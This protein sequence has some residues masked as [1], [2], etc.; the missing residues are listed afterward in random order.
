MALQL[1]SS[2]SPPYLS[3]YWPAIKDI[4]QT[5]LNDASISNL[6]DTIL[7]ISKIN[8]CERAEQID[9]LSRLSRVLKQ[10]R[11][12]A[13]NAEMP[14]IKTICQKALEIEDLFQ[15]GTIQLLQAL[16]PSKLSFKRNEIHCLLAHMFFGTFRCCSQ[17]TYCKEEHT[18]GPFSFHSRMSF[19]NWYSNKSYPTTDIY[20]NA[21]LNLFEDAGKLSD[22]D[23][24][25]DYRVEFERK[26]FFSSE[27]NLNYCD[28]P[29]VKVI[30]HSEGRIGDIEETEVDFANAYV[31]GGPGGTQ[32]ELMLG[33]S[34]ES[35]P[36]SILNADPLRSNECIVITGAKKYAEYKGYGLDAIYLGKNVQKWNWAA[37]KIIAI[38]ALWFQKG[39]GENRFEQM[40]EDLLRREVLKCFVGFSSQTNGI[41]TG[42]WGCG[43]FGGDKE[44]KAILQVI[45]ASAANVKH[46]NFFSF[47][48]KVFA[49]DFGS[50][51][52]AL[53]ENDIKVKDLWKMVIEE[54]KS[55]K[56]PRTY[57]E[58]YD[59]EPFI[60]KKIASNLCYQ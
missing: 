8:Q 15:S 37:R 51:L 18:G 44:I 38:D 43:A 58:R 1:P 21:I 50:M 17:N 40:R 33:I 47:G 20:L 39:T 13:E 41:S 11:G 22:S 45:G 36:I 5:L 59:P 60:F 53:Y 29:L 6:E 32:E 16:K 10:F 35:L 9:D 7:Q 52:Q 34:P 46:L 12:H 23:C 14:V 4:L 42:H 28:N 57:K 2:T 56:E 31:G 54:G 3:E 30:I 55:M 27:I 24:S 26:V 19:T 49:D 25:L 48:D